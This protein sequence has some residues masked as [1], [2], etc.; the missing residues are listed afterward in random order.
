MTSIGFDLYCKLL[1][2][3]LGQTSETHF[4]PVFKAYLPDHYISSERER[5]SIYQRFSQLSSINELTDLKFELED[6]YGKLPKLVDTLFE[7]LASQLALA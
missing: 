7:G 3:T 2:E 5:L 6:R 4:K 1:N